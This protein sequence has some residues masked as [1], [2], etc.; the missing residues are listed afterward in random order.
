MVVYFYDLQEVQKGATKRAARSWTS[1][2]V[3]APPPKAPS[4][5]ATLTLETGKMPRTTQVPVAETV[6]EKDPTRAPPAYAQKEGGA[7]TQT[8]DKTPSPDHS[9]P[10][11]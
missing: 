4:S 1:Q 7:V 6:A 3:A 5:G 8:K 9:N 11:V 2:T 10:K